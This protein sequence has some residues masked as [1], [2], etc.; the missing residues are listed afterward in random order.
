VAFTYKY[1]MILKSLQKF[2]RLAEWV[3]TAEFGPY[4]PGLEKCVD[5]ESAEKMLPLLTSL[6]FGSEFGNEVR[7]CK[8]NG[9]LSPNLR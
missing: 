1:A 5:K 3:E 6:G 7:S 2:D 9:K 4:E 8:F